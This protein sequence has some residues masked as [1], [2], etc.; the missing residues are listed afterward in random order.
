MPI[1]TAIIIDNDDVPED[2]IWLELEDGSILKLK[3]DDF[4]GSDLIKSLTV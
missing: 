1:P 3:I 2:E 4:Y